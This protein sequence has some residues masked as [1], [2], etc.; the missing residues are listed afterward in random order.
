MVVAMMA[1]GILMLVVVIGVTVA[2]AEVTR[3]TR[4]LEEKLH[5]P[6]VPTVRFVV[7]DGVDPAVVGGGLSSAGFTNVLEIEYGEEELLIECPPSEREHA[8]AVIAEI[9]GRMCQPGLPVPP[10]RFMDEAA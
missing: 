2:F 3:R 10:V 1:V 4:A 7:P 6:D 9:E 5:E 8:R